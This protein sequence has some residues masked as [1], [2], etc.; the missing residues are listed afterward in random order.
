[1][2]QYKRSRVLKAFFIH[3]DIGY[4]ESARVDNARYRIYKMFED[5]YFIRE[6]VYFPDIVDQLKK[7][8]FDLTKRF[9]QYIIKCIEEPALKRWN[10]DTE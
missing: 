3:H 1:M 2:P 6:D 5:Y 9:K 7:N 10:G 4:S 8:Q